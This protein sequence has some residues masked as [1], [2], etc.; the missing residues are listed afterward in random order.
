MT[1]TILIGY[2]LNL[3]LERKVSVSIRQQSLG[4]VP[5][6]V[7]RWAQRNKKNPIVVFADA[8]EDGFDWDDFTE[9]YAAEG[10]PAVH[11]GRLAIVTIL[12]HAFGLTD[13]QAVECVDTRLDW[14]YA[15]RMDVNDPA[16]D[17]TVLVEFRQRLLES[18]L[19]DLMLNKLLHIAHEK[20]ILKHSKQRTDSTHIL[21]NVRTL[22]RLERIH[23]AMRAAIDALLTHFPAVYMSFHDPNWIERYDRAPYRFKSPKEGKRRD[24]LAK[25]MGEDISTLLQAVDA[26]VVENQGL[27]ELHPITALR[28]IFEQ[29]YLEKGKG[30]ELRDD[31]ESIPPASRI[32]SPHDTDARFGKKGSTRWLG[33]STH[34][35]ETCDEDAPR[36][37]TNV[38]TVPGGPTDEH[39]LPKIHSSLKSRGYAPSQHFV[40]SGYTDVE[41]M[42]TSE[43][44]LGITVIGPAR[45]GPSWQTAAGKGFDAANFSIDFENKKATCPNGVTSSIWSE[46]STKGSIIVG[47]PAKECGRC[48]FRSD[49]TKSTSG[50]RRLEVKTADLFQ[51]LQRTR[52]R[53]QTTEFKELYRIRSGVEGTHSQAARTCRFRRSRYTGLQKTQLQSWLV[54]AGITAIRIARWLIGLPLSETRTTIREKL[55]A[56][57]A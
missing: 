2:V 23:E 43:E 37:I 50:G 54:A 22:G 18:G 3:T 27:S 32:A 51:Y 31:E 38:E 5:E 20:Q 39:M 7:A 24:A 36:L 47:F 28:A 33:Y 41:V 53:E 1:A 11:P 34:F 16:F 49:C 52:H 26:V 56:V 17:H 35:T 46:R 30:F 21:A 13:R 55:A 48:P 42:R 4:S 14:K 57:A 25:Q 29:Q 12:Q 9:M 40:D 44:Q 6:A 15:L 8:V 19:Q 45:P 10:Q